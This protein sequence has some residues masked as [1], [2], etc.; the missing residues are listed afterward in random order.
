MAMALASAGQQTI[1]PLLMGFKPDEESSWVKL[2]CDVNVGTVA[3]PQY[4][5]KKTQVPKFNKP[6][7][8]LLCRNVHKFYNVA[9]G[10]LAL[11]TGGSRFE[12]YWQTQEIST[13]E[14]SQ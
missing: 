5:H 12:Y 4:E 2:Y 8:E 9:D 14:W 1:I 3:N 13:G 10:V 6:D 7:I 11:T